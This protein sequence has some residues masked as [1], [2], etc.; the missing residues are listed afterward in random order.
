MRNH[1]VAMCARAYCSGF[2]SG[3]GR[4]C[5]C[6]YVDQRAKEGGLLGNAK[7]QRPF[8]QPIPRIRRSERRNENTVHVAVW[9][10]LE[11]DWY[12]A[13]APLARYMLAMSDETY[14]ERWNRSPVYSG[15]SKM[16]YYMSYILLH[17]LIS[18]A[19]GPVK[20]RHCR[21]VRV[22]SI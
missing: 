10:S 3:N 19:G 2:P 22:S 12:P 8:P 11:L 5:T 14:D 18:T 1:N 17:R 13:A 15:E 7:N 20:H 16:A 6:V 4:A 21:R 9:R